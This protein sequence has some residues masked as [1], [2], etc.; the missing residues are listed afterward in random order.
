MHDTHIFTFTVNHSGGL[1]VLSGESMSIVAEK[2]LSD[3]Q[4]QLDN[5]R[6]SWINPLQHNMVKEKL[7]M[8]EVEREIFKVCFLL[9]IPVAIKN[10]APHFV[11]SDICSCFT[12]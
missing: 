5:L 11:P 9:N 7:Q 6:S 12:Y 3:L 2:K 10:D 1:S 4:E 8:A